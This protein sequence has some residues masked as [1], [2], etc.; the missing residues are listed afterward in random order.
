MRYSDKH[1]G[2]VLLDACMQQ[3]QSTGR[4]DKNVATSQVLGCART[5]CASV[6][7]RPCL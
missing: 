1:Y 2:Q 5:P 6:I 3:Q 4:L 7:T